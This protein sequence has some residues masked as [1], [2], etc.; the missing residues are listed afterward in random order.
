MDQDSGFPQVPGLEVR[1]LAWYLTVPCQDHLVEETKAQAQRGGQ[2]QVVKTPRRKSWHGKCPAVPTESRRE[3]RKLRL[4]GSWMLGPEEG[5]LGP[6]W[7][8]VDGV[9]V[10]SGC[11]M[12]A[13]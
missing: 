5:L 7:E 10:C 6:R 8:R 2:Q 11:L 13:S 4:E 12:A 3:S 9:R 1:A